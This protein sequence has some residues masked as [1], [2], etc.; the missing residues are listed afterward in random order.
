MRPEHKIFIVEMGAYNKGGIDLLCRMAPPDMAMVT[1]VNEQHLATFGSWENLLSAEG[2]QE[3]AVNLGSHGILVVN[4][5]NS[6]CVDLYKNFKG[7][8]RIYTSKANTIDADLW[9]EQIEVKKEYLD[10]ALISRQRQAVHFQIK[11]LGAHNIQN[12]LGAALVAKEMG[13]S[14]EEISAAAKKITPRQAGITLSGGTHGINVIDSSYSSNPDGVA[15]DLDYLKIFEGKRVLVMPCLIELGE[16][17]AQIH[18]QLGKKIAQVCD[19]AIITTKD[20]FKELE[21]G[22]MSQGLSE[23]KM[24]LCESPQEIFNLQ[25]R[26]CGVAGRRP[27]KRINQIA[28]EIKSAT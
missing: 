9:A 14:L 3:L 25:R 17:S 27:A 16:K 1:G 19:L 5:E 6:Y 11:V 26:R 20:K 10:F 4:G 12:L 23:R 21:A 7:H 24:L 15:A 28:G 18:E 22:F 2:G 13:M 8:K